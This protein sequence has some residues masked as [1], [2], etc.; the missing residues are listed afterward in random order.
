M[1][2]FIPIFYFFRSLLLRGFINTVRLI[3]AEKANEIKYGISTS[4]IKKSSS[5]EF[6]HYQ[7]ASYKVLFRI[8]NKIVAQTKE[9]DF[10]DI[11]AGKGRAVFVAESFG[12]KNL[13]GI[14]MDK[15][16]FSDSIENL[17][18]YALKNKTS[19]ILFV[20]ANALDY[21]YK[22]KATVY[23]LFNP[24]NDTVLKKVLNQ[25]SSSTIKETWFVYMNPKYSKVF[26]P[27]KFET[28]FEIKTKRYLEA[29]IYKLKSY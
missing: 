7:G 9:L 28:V 4:S 21:N 6:F 10:V 19:N 8:F 22:N 14:E 16:L 3:R 29:I 25:I 1:K 15:N 18:T 11:G 2:V 23:F 24:F 17:K 26:T 20:D 27:E 5:N 12:Y 13:T